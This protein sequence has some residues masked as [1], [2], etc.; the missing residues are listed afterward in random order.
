MPLRDRAADAPWGGPLADEHMIGSVGN[1]AQF[2]RVQRL[3]DVGMEE[4]AQLTAGGPGRPEGNSKVT[5]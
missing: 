1:E 2:V 3:I 4:G 5:S